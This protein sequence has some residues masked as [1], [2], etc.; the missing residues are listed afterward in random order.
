MVVV[1]FKIFQWIKVVDQPKDQIHT[2]MLLAQLKMYLSL[3][4][5]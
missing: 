5:T 3:Q 4:H 2:V 1:V